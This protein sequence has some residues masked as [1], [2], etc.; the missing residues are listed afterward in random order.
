MYRDR[1]TALLEHII[2]F[3]IRI[4]SFDSKFHVQVQYSKHC[5]V[6]KMYIVMKKNDRVT[7]YLGEFKFIFKTFITVTCTE[8]LIR[9]SIV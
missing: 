8:F 4:L 5:S 1:V 9:I 6:C 2:T 3:A 7:Q